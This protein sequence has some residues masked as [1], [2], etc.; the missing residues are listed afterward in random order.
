MDGDKR[1]VMLITRFQAVDRDAL[2][3]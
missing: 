1:T 2:L 3:D